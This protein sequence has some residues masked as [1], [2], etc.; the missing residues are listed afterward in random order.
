M[1]TRSPI[2]AFGITRGEL[3]AIVGG[4]GKTTLRDLLAA[5]AHWRNWRVINTTTTKSAAPEGIAAE[6]CVLEADP[7]RR[8]AA[9]CAMLDR[10]RYAFVVS[11]REHAHR[12]I[13]VDPDWLESV[14]SRA[15]L[16][17]AEADGAR[18]KPLKAPADY[19]PVIPR[20]ASLVIAVV[21]A[22]VIGEP[23]DETRVHRLPLFSAATGLKAGD[24]LDPEALASFIESSRGYRKSVP[25]G[26]RFIPFIN[27][28]SRAQ[29]GMLESLLAA[30][31]SG[32]V[33]WGEARENRFEVRDA[34]D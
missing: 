13:G 21:G 5:D 22:E 11:A 30:L 27:K 17:V 8:T 34:G 3:V 16:V 6:R 24:R 7:D 31:G 25:D 15:D 28:V 26:A 20:S 23:I 29:T 32:R 4:G 2:G 12:F 33:V 1:S 10:E 9:V 14:R 19:E 18:K